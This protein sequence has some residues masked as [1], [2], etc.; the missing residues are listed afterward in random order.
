MVSRALTLLYGIVCYLIFF[1]TFLY[2]I[3]FVGDLIVPKTLDSGV[4]QDF[5]AALAVDAGLL[6]IFAVQHSVMA[7]PWF[8]RIW[9]VVIPQQVERSTYVLLSS[10][11]LV[12]LFW[13]WRPIGGTVWEVE[14][15]V[16]RA[17]LLALFVVGWTLVLVST[18]LTNHFDLF[19]LR[20]AWMYFQKQPY[21]PIRFESRSLY[22]FVRH[23][24]YVGWLL[25]FWASPLMT[26]AH[27]VFAVTTSAYIVVAI[28]FEEKDLIQ[29]HG[30]AYLRYREEVPMLLPSLRRRT[31]K[32]ASH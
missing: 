8:K 11:C 16:G 15:P 20:Q 23:P 5:G 18:L 13:Q 29:V 4:A 2:A 6:L 27:L 3:G 25:A 28:G 1:G 12:L 31:S 7:R 32:S 22:K 24:L 21:V 30:E 14:Q 17:A 19:G 10:L 9:T 26:A